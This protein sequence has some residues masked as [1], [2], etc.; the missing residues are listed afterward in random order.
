MKPRNDPEVSAW[1]VKVQ[2][3][4]RIAELAL[5]QEPPI[6][7]P[8]CFH[9]QQAAEKALKAVLV[10]HEIEVPHTHDVV[11]L[12]R[13]LSKEYAAAVDLREPA[14]VLT[15]Y[16]V[17]TRYPALRPGATIDEARAALANAKA[18]LSWVEARLP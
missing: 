11:W 1:L 3:D 6:V 4:L 7:E 10:A 18:I 8:A 15:T 13:I 16:G 14:A 9:A 2:D 12:V 5:E 17:S